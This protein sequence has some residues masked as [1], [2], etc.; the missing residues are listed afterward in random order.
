MTLH[1]IIVVLT[2]P[3]GQPQLTFPGAAAGQFIANILNLY[4]EVAI[5]AV[6]MA[7]G[8]HAPYDRYAV[9]R[10]QPGTVSA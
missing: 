4:S 7:G 2:E 9:E 10:G 1:G 8:K 5:I 3:L 6:R